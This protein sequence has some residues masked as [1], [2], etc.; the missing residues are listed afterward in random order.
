MRFLVRKSESSELHDSESHETGINSALAG[1]ENDCAGEDQKIFT[2]SEPTWNEPVARPKRS[3]EVTIK[4]DHRAIGWV[5]R[6]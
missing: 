2:V 6:N 1:T 3:C 4:L 5:G